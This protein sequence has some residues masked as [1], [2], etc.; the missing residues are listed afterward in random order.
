MPLAR[1]GPN[2]GLVSLA[3]A[4]GVLGAAVVDAVNP[5]AIA[6][7]LYLLRLDDP[8]GRA[9]AYVA[10]IFTLY[11]AV[12]TVLVFGARDGIGVAID[13]LS[14]P[15]A[16]Y[17]VE[18]IVGIVVIAF[19]LRRRG[20]SRPAPNTA[21]ASPGRAFLLGMTVT[22]VE[23][24]TAVPYLGAIALVIRSDPG[25]PATLALL[26]V[27]NFVLIAPPVALI[28]FARSNELRL[29]ALAARMARPLPDGVA[30]VARVGAV[31]LGV[32]LVADSIVFLVRGGRDLLSG[33]DATWVTS[34]GAHP[35][36]KVVF[37][38]APALADL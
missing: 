14:R 7:T 33:T 24:T 35:S 9:W 37:L 12:G 16:G 2:G 34:R 19:A 27:Y 15:T 20:S 23:A 31:V 6:M 30:R 22:A 1:C 11:L 28:L 25:V 5:S 3:L 8:W 32:V 21:V 18:G 4:L 38:A 36:G 29:E 26:V 17:V 13:V 10:G